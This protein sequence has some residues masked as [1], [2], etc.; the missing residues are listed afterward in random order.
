M[1]VMKRWTDRSKLIILMDNFLIHLKL[2]FEFFQ[3]LSKVKIAITALTRCQYFSVELVLLELELEFCNHKNTNNNWLIVDL[4]HG[5]NR[6]IFTKRR[7]LLR[8][9]QK[10]QKLQLD[11]IF[12]W[13]LYNIYENSF[14][15]NADN[16][17][18]IA[19]I[20]ND[21]EFDKISNIIWNW[22]INWRFYDWNWF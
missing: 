22:I 7:T 16:I 12:K 11:D 17:Q 15:R 13:D 4:F 18:R 10:N 5:P 6:Y 8:K 9:L 1:K 2:I 3:S 19:T 21:I 14:V 20:S